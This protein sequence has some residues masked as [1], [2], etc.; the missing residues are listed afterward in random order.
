MSVIQPHGIT[1]EGATNDF[2]IQLIPLADAHLGLLYKWNADVEVMYWEDGPDTEGY[3]EETVREIYNETSSCGYTFLILVDG[4]PIG[5]C[6]LC[7]MNLDYVLEKYAD[8]TDV[9]RIDILIG[10]KSFWG[11]GVGFEVVRM[12][13]DFAFNVE[14]TDVLYGI[15][16]EMN[17]RS[18]RIFEKNGFYLHAQLPDELHFR[19]TREE[20]IQK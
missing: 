18:M 1:L 13:A 9:R 16:S 11:R 14:S 12:L 5:E 6:L 10:E 17:K 8:K 4:Q 15:T 2:N 19:L 20:F 3:D 7:K